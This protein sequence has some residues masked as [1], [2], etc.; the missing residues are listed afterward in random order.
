MS[1]LAAIFPLSRSGRP[2]NVEAGC[3]DAPIVGRIRRCGPGAPDKG[4]AM[5]RARSM[6]WWRKGLVLDSRDA[7]W[8]CWRVRA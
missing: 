5:E 2:G 4:Q 7:K 6:P 3:E 8:W 1:D